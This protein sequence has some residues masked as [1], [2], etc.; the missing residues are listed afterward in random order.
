MENGNQ[1]IHFEP[2]I[3]QRATGMLIDQEGQVDVA[4]ALGTSQNVISRL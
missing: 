4:E 2:D 3:T 1:C